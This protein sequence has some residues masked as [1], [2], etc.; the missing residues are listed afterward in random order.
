MGSCF[1]WCNDCGK[2]SPNVE[3]T[4]CPY[5]GS[6]NISFDYE[7]PEKEGEGDEDDL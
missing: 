6:E 5:C 2:A 7:V 1:S 3:W 4:E